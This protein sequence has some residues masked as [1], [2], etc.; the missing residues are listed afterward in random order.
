MFFKRYF[1]LIIA[2][3]AVLIGATSCDKDTFLKT[4]T[5][6]YRFVDA[7]HINIYDGGSISIEEG[8]DMEIHLHTQL[9]IP[10]HYGDEPL[11]FK[12][13]ETGVRY[14]A[15]AGQMYDD[16]STDYKAA[17]NSLEY[18]F[19]FNLLDLTIRM[20]DFNIND[21]DNDRIYI[22]LDGLILKA[23]IKPVESTDNPYSEKAEIVYT[24]S[25]RD[26]NIVIAT[27]KQDYENIPKPD[28]PSGKGGSEGG[29]DM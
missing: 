12:P 24:L 25:T 19:H 15:L 18:T 29:G 22:C 16:E 6:F 9:L 10:F 2:A 26:S 5:L 27:A 21:P 20:T 23:E 28:N 8:R 1:F 13:D 14:I 7:N 3:I 17:L 4:E 11:K